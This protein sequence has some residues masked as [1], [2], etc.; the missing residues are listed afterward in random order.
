[1]MLC[2]MHLTRSELQ[3]LKIKIMIFYLAALQRQEFNQ[4]YIFCYAKYPTSKSFHILRWKKAKR[5][6]QASATH[7]W[8]KKKV[9]LFSFSVTFC[10]RY[11]YIYF[12][13]SLCQQKSELGSCFRSKHVMLREFWVFS[14]R[15]KNSPSATTFFP[16]ELSI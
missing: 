15:S 9:L 7:F 10:S 3:K 14:P 6:S 13:T 5:Q 2:K 16:S 12:N 4:N 8:K 11:T 1:M